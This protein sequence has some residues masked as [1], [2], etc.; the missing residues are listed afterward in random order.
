MLGTVGL[1]IQVTADGRPRPKT[2]GV[3]IDWSTVAAVS[4]ADVTLN[5]G[6][7]IPIGRKYLR[8]G[9]IITEITTGG[10][11]G[12]YDPAAA[13]GR[14]TL[15]RGKCWI[16]NRTVTDNDPKGDHPEAIDG[17]TVFQARLI[18][19]GAGTRSLA[20]GPTLA[21]FEAA[22]PTIDYCDV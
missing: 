8:Y 17:G 12:P 1:G 4:G 14:Q 22:F 9:Q 19:V 18:Q 16:V 20:A 21:E 15:A 2:G 13:D 10:K 5:D 11:Y 6:V 3:T 7:I